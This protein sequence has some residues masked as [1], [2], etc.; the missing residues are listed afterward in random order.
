[1]LDFRDGA[2]ISLQAGPEIA[3]AGTYRCANCSPVALAVESTA[4]ELQTT[5]FMPKTP[6]DLLNRTDLCI[7]CVSHCARNSVQALL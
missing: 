1:M 7:V 5:K 4:L 3:F 6:R 2:E